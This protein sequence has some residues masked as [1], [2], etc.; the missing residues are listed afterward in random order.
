VVPWQL[1]VHAWFD[2]TRA[3]EPLDAGA[4]PGGVPDTYPFGL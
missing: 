3:V 1:D 4:A 2:Q